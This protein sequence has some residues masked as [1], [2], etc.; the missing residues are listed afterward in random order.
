LIQPSVVVTGAAGFIGSTL[1]TALLARGCRVLGIDN[2]DPLYDPA[3]KRENVARIQRGPNAACFHFVH[4]DV[5]DA[6]AL[7]TLFLQHAPHAVFHLA[8]LAGVRRSIEQ[9]RRYAD[10]NITGLVNTLQACRA[11]NCRQVVF[12]SSSSVYGNN[13]KT[14]FSEDDSVENPIRPYAATKRAGEIIA[15]SFARAYGLR[16][17]ALRLFTVFGPAQRPDLAIARFMR[18]IAD[19]EPVPMF[20]DGSTLRDYTFVSDAV[21]GILAAWNAIDHATPTS[22]RAGEL[23]GGGYFRTWNIGS[24]RPTALRDMIDAIAKVVGKPARIS[25]KPM[26]PGDVQRTWADLTRSRAELGYQAVTNLA[27]N[28]R[29]QWASCH[30]AS[31]IPAGFGVPVGSE[32]ELRSA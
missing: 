1:A 28:L 16:I 22:H 10:V 24:D 23:S 18:L 13:V 21:S 19:G 7:N 6:H 15:Q 3:I 14:P 17:A 25:P 12:A 2:F 31:T 29:V 30:N 4:A 5:L 9:P 8:A 32:P 27:D 26:Q 20:G 11:A